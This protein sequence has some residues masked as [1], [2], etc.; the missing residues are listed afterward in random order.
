MSVI[1]GKDGQSHWDSAKFDVFFKEMF[2]TF[3]NKNYCISNST[4][5]GKSIVVDAIHNTE[6]ENWLLIILKAC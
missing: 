2:G 1:L 6:F 3:K 4:G 5:M